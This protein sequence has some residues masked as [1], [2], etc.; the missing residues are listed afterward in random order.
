M[1]TEPRSLAAVGLFLRRGGGDGWLSGALFFASVNKNGVSL[2]V[3][4]KNY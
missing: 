1:H 2:F 3:S 4:D